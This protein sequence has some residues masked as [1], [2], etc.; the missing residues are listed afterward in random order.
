MLNETLLE[1]C[2]AKGG[3]RRP[4]GGIGAHRLG[5]RVQDLAVRRKP[6]RAAVCRGLNVNRIVV[7]WLAGIRPRIGRNMG[8]ASAVEDGVLE[9]IRRR[10]PTRIYTCDPAAVK[11]GG[12]KARTTLS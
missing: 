3:Y 8:T 1:Y 10:L 11:D 5:V 9:R 4:V 2:G 7:A 6:V 12:Q